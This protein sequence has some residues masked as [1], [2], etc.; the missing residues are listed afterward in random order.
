MQTE[1][2]YTNF[3]YM[4][5]FDQTTSFSQVPSMDDCTCN[6]CTFPALVHYFLAFSFW[7]YTVGTWVI[8]SQM[9]C[10]KSVFS[11]LYF[12]KQGRLFY[13][14]NWCKLLLV[15]CYIQTAWLL[16]QVTPEG[17]NPPPWKKAR[18]G[19]AGLLSLDGVCLELNTSVMLAD[20]TISLVHVTPYTHILWR[21]SDSILVPV[22]GLSQ[23]LICQ[24]ARNHFPDSSLFPKSSTSLLLLSPTPVYTAKGSP[25]TDLQSLKHSLPEPWITR[26]CLLFTKRDS[27]QKIF[28]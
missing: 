27:R 10:F 8:S 17:P 20:I 14:S 16:P 15:I 13:N 18:V 6:A 22:S 26:K 23:E 1:T 11:W 2:R 28:H 3:N 5:I 4:S 12:A 25:Y 7:T 9:N 21:Y 19:G 24:E